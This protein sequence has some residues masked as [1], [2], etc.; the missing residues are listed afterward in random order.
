MIQGCSPGVANMASGPVGS[1]GASAECLRGGRGDIGSAMQRHGS[2]AVQML[3]GHKCA[4]MK[5]SLQEKVN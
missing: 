3:L 4:P 2:A 5:R 1:A